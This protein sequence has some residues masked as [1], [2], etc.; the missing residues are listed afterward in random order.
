MG[1]G[2]AIAAMAEPAD[3]ELFRHTQAYRTATRARNALSVRDVAGRRR[4]VA[5]AGQDVEAPH[6]QQ[7][8]K[9]QATV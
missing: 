9:R 7:C 2:D 4:H 3:G 5:A 6:Q 1:V 8:V